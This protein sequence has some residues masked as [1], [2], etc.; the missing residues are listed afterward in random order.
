ME[1][2]IS[3]PFVV[4]DTAYVLKYTK[5]SRN[6]Y[7]IITDEVGQT[8]NLS[9]GGEITLSVAGTYT[10]TQSGE[11][12]GCVCDGQLH[13]NA[14]IDGEASSGPTAVNLNSIVFPDKCMNVD[15]VPL[16]IHPVTT[17]NASTGET[18]RTSYYDLMGRLVVG[19]ITPAD[20]CD[21]KDCTGCETTTTTTTTTTAAPT[22]TTTTSTTTAAPVTQPF[23]LFSKS[24]NPH[25]DAANYPG[26]SFIGTMGAGSTHPGGADVGSAISGWNVFAMCAALK[27]ADDSNGH[28]WLAGL[29]STLSGTV[30]YVSSPNADPTCN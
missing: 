28:Y 29:P 6:C 22:T 5:A 16:L 12:P 23:A 11:S 2:S 3:N 15:G 17:I 1:I 19:V 10:F 13:A 30:N 27:P 24:P 8:R 7:I 14:V 21:C 4:I 20:D 9:P 25:P 18:V 26:I